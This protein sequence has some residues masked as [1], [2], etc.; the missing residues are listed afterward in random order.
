MK[1]L[2]LEI[3]RARLG[4]RRGD[5]LGG[6][7]HLAVL[8]PHGSAFQLIAA[9]LPLEVSEVIAVRALRSERDFVAFDAAFQLQL[10][11]AA[12]QFFT[13]R[14]EGD[15][16]VGD[17]AQDLA[18]EFPVAGYVAREETAGGEQKSAESVFRMDLLWEVRT[19]GAEKSSVLPIPT[20]TKGERTQ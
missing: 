8:R 4:W 2:G 5:A 6:P 12:G 16:G 20:Y 3:M 17:I 7:G 11:E 1:F 9:Y 19:H 14:L 15:A 13:L 18:G 10:V